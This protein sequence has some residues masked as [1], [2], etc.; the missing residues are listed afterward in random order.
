[1][2]R[3]R[4][5]LPAPLGPVISTSS[6]LATLKLTS[7]KTALRPKRLVTCEMCTAA[8]G[9]GTGF[10]TPFVAGRATPGPLV[11]GLTPPPP[12]APTQGGGA[13]APNP[14]W[15]TPYPAHD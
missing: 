10:A 5:V 1:M 13:V 7:A 11:A 14:P 8:A 6:P 2:R 12:R 3:S 4:V 15:S 9:S